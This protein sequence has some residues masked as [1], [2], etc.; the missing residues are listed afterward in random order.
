MAQPCLMSRPHR[1][2]RWR[3]SQSQGPSA[4][5]ARSQRCGPSPC[6]TLCGAA[7]SS[8]PSLTLAPPS[9]TSRWA[10]W[11]SMA[12]SLQTRKR[13]CWGRRTRRSSRRGAVNATQAFGSPG[14]AVAWE[15]ARLGVRPEH[16]RQGVA[17]L[18]VEAL[19]RQ[20]VEVARPGDV[21]Y[22]ELPRNLEAP[23][24][25]FE[26]LGFEEVPF[27]EPLAPNA[28]SIPPPEVRMVYRGSMALRAQARQEA[29]AP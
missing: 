17:T 2:R 29:A 4:G 18:L 16:R 15:L 11:R 13:P 12:S 10:G 23:R 7:R 26:G 27:G 28:G 25:L 19:L 24:A 9:G 8:H 1:G 6:T 5:T 22:V 3:G 20:Y 21:L 14:G